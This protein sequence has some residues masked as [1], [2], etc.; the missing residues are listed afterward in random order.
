MSFNYIIF[1]YIAISI[2]F[3]VI[4]TLILKLTMPTSEDTDFISK[5]AY[6]ICFIFY[7]MALLLSIISSKI[8]IIPYLPLFPGLQL[9][10]LLLLG[11]IIIHS[12]L[13][14]KKIN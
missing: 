8:F 11:F 1:Q 9:I 4:N 7:Q 5:N 3:F 10:V 12:K 13:Y 14:I 6:N 2:E